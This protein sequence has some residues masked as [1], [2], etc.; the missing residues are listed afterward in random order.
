MKIGKIYISDTLIDDVKNNGKNAFD[1]CIAFSRFVPISV[2]Y[3]AYE[4]V[5]E[6]VGYSPDFTESNEGELKLYDAIINTKTKKVQF[7][8]TA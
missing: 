7:N 1:I 2:R 4:R 3:L 8:E 5:Y 6:Y